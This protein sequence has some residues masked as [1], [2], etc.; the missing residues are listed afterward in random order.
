MV[1]PPRAGGVDYALARVWI[2]AL[3]PTSRANRSSPP[4]G[5]GGRNAGRELRRG[6]SAKDPALPGRLRSRSGGDGRHGAHGRVRQASRSLLRRHAGAHGGVRIPS[7]PRGRGAVSGPDQSIGRHPAGASSVLP[8]RILSLQP[9]AVSG[10][11]P[12]AP[13]SIVRLPAGRLRSRGDVRKAARR[14][15]RDSHDLLL[16]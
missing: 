4:R 11:E 12:G 5:G 9:D 3:T 8:A 1:T 14:P 16:A 7:G 2:M 6:W 10:P 13:E 15:L